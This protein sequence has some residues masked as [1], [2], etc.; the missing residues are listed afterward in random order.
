MNRYG[1]IGKSL[2]HSFSKS[3]FTEKFKAFEIQAEYINIELES[4]EDFRMVFHQYPQLK[5]INV[6]IP[7][8]TEVIPFL[9]HLSPEA[10]KIQAVNCIKV[11]LNGDEVYLSG[12]N[13]DYI[14]IIETLKLWTLPLN[15][16][17]LILGT[18]GAAKAVCYALN[19]I[20]IPYLL[21]SRNGNFGLNYDQI[22]KEIMNDFNLIINTTPIGTFPNVEE[23][24]AIPLD[25]ISPQHFVFDLIYNPSETKLLKAAKVNGAQICNGLHMLQ[26]QA[27]ASWKIWN[28]DFIE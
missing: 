1:L 25:L 26:V 21:V 22:G 2:S 27:E 13:T 23:A 11:K 9:Q 7:Y 17:A 12:Y 8:K 28:S 10:E 6:T 24:P 3:Y 5:G 16:Q 15:T 4:I 20:E 19:L 14:G 18:G